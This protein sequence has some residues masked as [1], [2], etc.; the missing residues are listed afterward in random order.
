MKISI[1]TTCLNS[2]STIRETIESV[3]NQSGNFQLEYIVT[4]AGSTDGTLEILAEYKDKL[5]LIS[6]CGMNQSQ[7]INL[8][9]THASGEI[10]A[11]LNADDVYA[12]NAIASVVAAFNKN[13]N[14]LWLYGQCRI[15]D[16]KGLE[17]SNWIT[18]YKNFWQARYSY[19]TL[20]AENFICQ[21]AVFW[22]KQLFE[23]YHGFAEH[24]NLAM[25]YEYW[26]RIGYANKPIAIPKVLAAFR[27][28]KGSKSSL[29]YM[30]QFKDDFRI[31]AGYARRTR[32]Y[33]P[34]VLKCFHFCKTTMTYTMLYR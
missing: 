15:I 26:L 16:D 1:V 5:R 6:A 17:C 23:L 25:D 27:R 29:F 24:E 22:R 14:S 33:L 12:P 4:D 9:L 3:L 30:Q 7:G 18:R 2:A 13:P 28:S 32:F 31:A 10:M 20:L 11:F 8:G 19:F 21:P 34:L